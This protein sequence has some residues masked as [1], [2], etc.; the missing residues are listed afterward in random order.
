MPKPYPLSTKLFFVGAYLF[1]MLGMSQKALAAEDKKY[2]SAEKGYELA[3]KF[4]K[5]CHLIDGNSVDPTPAGPP[6]FSWIANKP[7][8]TADRIKGSLLLPHPP[9]PD[10]HLSNDEIMD[11]IAYLDTLRSD[12]AAPPFVPPPGEPKPKYP[13]PT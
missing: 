1:A 13:S 12:E 8:Q 11:V 6:P 4:C 5:T 3:S 10:M 2:P 7:G 9:M